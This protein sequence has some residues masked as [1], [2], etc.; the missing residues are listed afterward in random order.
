MAEWIAL[1][2][3]VSEEQGKNLDASKERISVNLLLKWRDIKLTRLF[4]R[5]LNV[6]VLDG[7]F[8]KIHNKHPD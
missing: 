3:L 6:D 5:E 7:C 2:Y 8:C 4:L 1:H